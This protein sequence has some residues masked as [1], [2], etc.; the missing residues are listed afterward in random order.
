M[1]KVPFSKLEAKVCETCCSLVYHNTKGEAIQYEVKY[2]LPIEEKLDMIT[3]IINK[4]IDEHGFYNPVRVQIFTV[5]EVTQAYTNLSF[6]AKQKENI[7]KL[8][9][10]LV[11]TKIFQ[12]IKDVIWEEDWKEIENTVIAVMD[13]IYKYKNSAMGILESIASDYQDM[14]FEATEIQKKIGDP[15]NLEL[16]KN[17]LTQLG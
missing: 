4:S 2:Y 6:T 11:S 10:Q 3:N 13:N 5:L 16:L 1:A 17:V 8:Y 15:A 9:D 14:D 12:N 7:F